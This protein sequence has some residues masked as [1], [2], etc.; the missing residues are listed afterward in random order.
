MD[1]KY[2]TVQVLF[3]WVCV[4]WVQNRDVPGLGYISICELMYIPQGLV[5]GQVFNVRVPMKG[6]GKK[7]EIKE[8]APPSSVWTFLPTISIGSDKY[9][10]EAQTCGESCSISGICCPKVIYTNGA[11]NEEAVYNHSCGCCAACFGKFQM[12]WKGERVGSIEAAGCC[13]QPA[14]YAKFEQPIY[15]EDFSDKKVIAKIT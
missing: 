10:K 12:Q 4:G 3:V 1:T 5:P 8:A 9:F 7:I 2:V 14:L 6:G 11:K 15:S 13:E